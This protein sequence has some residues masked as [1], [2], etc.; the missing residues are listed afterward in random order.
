MKRFFLSLIFFSLFFQ[1]KAQE[2][3]VVNGEKYALANFKKD[4]AKNIEVEGYDKALKNYTEYLLMLQ[5]GKKLQ[6]DTTHYY[7]NLLNQKKKKFNGF[8]LIK[9]FK[10]I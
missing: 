6:V 3:I 8:F 1:A 9:S 10:I 2:S 5:R 7:Q 4:F